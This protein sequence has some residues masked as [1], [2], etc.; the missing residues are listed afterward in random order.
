MLTAQRKG[1]AALL[2]RYEGKFVTV[3]TTILS[4]KPGFQ[5]VQQPQNNYIDEAVDNKLRKL[6]ILPSPLSADSRVSPPRVP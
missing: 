5:W 4:N 3:S 6:R 1:E 2:V